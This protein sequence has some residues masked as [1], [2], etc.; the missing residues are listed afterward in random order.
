MISSLDLQT[1]L[2]SRLE[3]TANGSLNDRKSLR[4]LMGWW[5]VGLLV[6]VPGW[7]NEA[8]SWDGI[9][10]PLPIQCAESMLGPVLELVRLGRSDEGTHQTADTGPLP[11]E[12]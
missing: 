11:V 4:A 10:P 1:Y 7:S 12:L 5:I 8:E 3:T 9:D 2:I 6:M